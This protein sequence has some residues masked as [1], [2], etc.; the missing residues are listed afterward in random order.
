MLSFER[1]GHGRP[2]VLVPGIGSRRQV[3]AQLVDALPDGYEV[4]ALDLPGHG[5]SPPLDGGRSWSVAAYVETVERFLDALDLDEQP[6]VV[7]NS[8]GGAIALELACHGRTA[9]AVAIAP[10]GFWRG[11]EVSWCI[12]SL[13]LSARLGEPLVG[14]AET[15]MRSRIARA[16][17]LGQ[18]FGR[19]GAVSASSAAE[20]LRAFVAAGPAIRASVPWTRRYRFAGSP[21][22]VPV[23]IV[24]GMRDL[25][26]PCWQARRA[27][28]ALPAARRAVLRTGGHVGMVDDPGAV[29]RFIDELVTS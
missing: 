24:W 8:L 17:L 2:L 19:P 12:A 1:S 10:I 5:A 21:P 4:I 9:A 11:P 25:L 7:G 27:L 6:V 13:R 18:M 28:A 20:E 26:L 23:G 29:A 22:E 14:H 16:L 15:L 3:W